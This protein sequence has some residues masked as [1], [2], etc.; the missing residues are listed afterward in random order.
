ML[1][2]LVLSLASAR[3]DSTLSELLA[4]P[5]QEDGSDS[6]LLRQLKELRDEV[7]QLKEAREI[8]TEEFTADDTPW[9]T[10]EEERDA[11]FFDWWK[12]KPT[13]GLKNADKDC[14]HHCGSKSG[15]CSFCGTGKCC[16]AY[17]W[18]DKGDCKAHEGGWI[19]HNCVA[20]DAKPAPKPSPTSKPT[21]PK[22][23]TSKPTA[24]KPATAE[25]TA[26]KTA[27]PCC[28]AMTANCLACAAGMSETEYCAKNPKTAGCP[29]QNGNVPS[30]SVLC[31]GK[32]ESDY[33]DCTGDCTEK[34]E[35]CTCE[36]AQKCCAGKDSGIPSDSVLCPG[37]AKSDYCDCTGDCTEM[38]EF[39][40]CEE[41][42][43]CCKGK[44]GDVDT[45][46]QDW[47]DKSAT[48][49]DRCAAYADFAGIAKTK[50]ACYNCD[51]GDTGVRICG[52]VYCKNEPAPLP[53]KQNEP[54][55]PNGRCPESEPEP[56]S[57]C[58]IPGKKCTYGEECCCGECHASMTA[59]CVPGKGDASMWMLMYTHAC[60]DPICESSGISG[61]A[62]NTII[63]VET[64][65]MVPVGTTFTAGTP[66]SG[67]KSETKCGS[68]TPSDPLYV[69][70]SLCPNA[71]GEAL[72]ITK[73]DQLKAYLDEDEAK[74]LIAYLQKQ[75]AT[76]VA[77]LSSEDAPMCLTSKGGNLAEEDFTKFLDK[78]FN[79]EVSTKASSL[80]NH[81][82]QFLEL[83]GANGGSDYTIERWATVYAGTKAELVLVPGTPVDLDVDGIFN[84]KQLNYWMDFAVMSDNSLNSA[85][86]LLEAIVDVEG[87]K[88]SLKSSTD[89]AK[90]PQVNKV[91]TIDFGTSAKSTATAQT[92]NPSF[93]LT[94]AE[95]FDVPA[96]MPLIGSLLGMELPVKDLVQFEVADI[97]VGFDLEMGDLCLKTMRAFAE[98]PDIRSIVDEIDP[99]LCADKLNPFDWDLCRLV[100]LRDVSLQLDTES[101]GMAGCYYKEAPELRTF[102]FTGTPNVEFLDGDALQITLGHEMSKVFV[103]YN[104][105]VMH[106]G[107]TITKMSGN[108]VWTKI[109]EVITMIGITDV[110]ISFATER[111]T[112]GNY[113]PMAL[114]NDANSDLPDEYY[115]R[116][117]GKF[118]FPLFPEGMKKMNTAE[119]FEIEKNLCFFTLIQS[120]QCC[121]KCGAC[122]FI[123]AV[124]GGKDLL[125]ETNIGASVF[126]MSADV[127][128]TYSIPI[129]DY[130]TLDFYNLGF[131]L[132]V[133]GGITSFGFKNSLTFT[134][135]DPKYN[136]PIELIG[137]VAIEKVSWDGPEDE[138][139]K[140]KE[141][142]EGKTKPL[143]VAENESLIKS[144]ETD[145]FPDPS[146]LD[147]LRR[148]A[149]AADAATDVAKIVDPTSLF[150]LRM[151]FAF[152]TKDP[153]EMW[154][155]ALGIPNFAIKAVALSLGIGIV[156]GTPPRPSM[157]T[158]YVKDALMAKR[159]QLNKCADEERMA[160]KDADWRGDCLTMSG[161]INL[162]MT[163][164]ANNWGFFKL[165]SL[166]FG[167][168]CSIF[169][170]MDA[171]KIPKPLRETGFDVPP[172]APPGTNALEFH[173][174]MKKVDM[175][176][177]P[178]LAELDGPEVFLP[179]FKFE[180]HLNMFGTFA[181]AM[182]EWNKGKKQIIIDA[183]MDPIVFSKKR[184]TFPHMLGRRRYDDRDD[185]ESLID[186]LEDRLYPHEER[187]ERGFGFGW[188]SQPTK[189]TAP[190]F[191]I[192]HADDPTKGPYLFVDLCGDPF[193]CAL[194]GKGS[195]RAVASLS[196][197]IKIGDFLDFKASV[198]ISAKL[199]SVMT[200]GN[201]YAFINVDTKLGAFQATGDIEAEGWASIP[202]LMNGD[203][204]WMARIMLKVEGLNN[205]VSSFFTGMQKSIES[206][207]SQANIEMDKVT[208]ALQRTYEELDKKCMDDCKNGGGCQDKSYDEFW[209]CWDACG[210]NGWCDA[211][212]KHTHGARGRCCR[213]GHWDSGCGVDKGIWGH[214]TCVGEWY[215]DRK[216]RSTDEVALL[217]PQ[218][219]ARI[220]GGLLDG[221]SQLDKCM[222]KGLRCACE[223]TCAGVC[224]MASATVKLAINA[225]KFH[226]DLLNKF[227][228]LSKKINNAL[229]KFA[230]FIPDVKIEFGGEISKMAKELYVRVHVSQDGFRGQADKNWEFNLTI[231]LSSPQKTF[232][233]IAE[234]FFKLISPGGK[235]ADQL[236]AEIDKEV[237]DAEKNKN[238]ARRRIEFEL[239]RLEAVDATPQI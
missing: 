94:S 136:W 143:T 147:P 137:T 152:Q 117:P 57:A 237:A 180:G 101:A 121:E 189:V 206:A 106:I 47:D 52:C 170:D 161:A 230:S 172:D 18:G 63:P 157:F 46:A 133:A 182:V 215:G 68:F 176:A 59:S 107:N 205:Q 211:C 202:S 23:A 126:K 16:R 99:T 233:S 26:P 90:D 105:P 188:P 194:D 36:E 154:K 228:A 236:K 9:G 128:G 231:D 209:N 195:S 190:A 1:L 199:G 50:D 2:G 118:S 185:L 53:A 220:I 208:G 225:V 91:K 144:L 75:E 210:G 103:L 204:S 218:R 55:L 198:N 162:D 54:T 88:W 239:R 112:L 129:G 222:S 216:T 10:L 149:D 174:A 146:L 13:P 227:G 102:T 111:I 34:P 35:F 17:Y 130:G 200:E 203:A 113:Q 167:Q 89:P 49:C 114:A 135:D 11:R 80:Q 78:F 159:G 115:K 207:I 81:L 141:A 177:D 123:G 132:N 160:T 224:G 134:S 29:Q 165:S 77:F 64:K 191:S 139:E 20:G 19:A 122:Q 145:D 156:P 104:I 5:L 95:P 8:E 84:V 38:P 7:R 97:E 27:K 148:R 100:L 219:E 169:L 193:W 12:P 127:V 58:A 235:S 151:G 3:R 92:G 74:K 192:T 164:N 178:L 33:C 217:E 197:R 51:C 153:N 56:M 31:P 166:T 226:Q 150:Q 70:C 168:M 232:K 201:G 119:E 223:G 142:E 175:T 212:L 44:G 173:V 21:A 179:G 22:P 138:K 125:I 83:F 131:F 87:Q 85:T 238:S 73:A 96:M 155:N 24:P 45:P 28:F 71:G 43:K 163:P 116:Q 4:S 140:K 60:M 214:H 187:D 61:K 183:E 15:T 234:A 108:D 67:Q 32:A 30:D 184:F 72:E 229:S 82:S 40:T 39:C 25:P 221:L 93:E 41:A 65:T 76:L 120:S 213:K 109:A 171:S 186:L 158:F 79:P 124:L 110:G 66:P 98:K 196:G 69:A 14:W 181:Y 48:T 62:P 6:R 42:Q 37:K 86:V